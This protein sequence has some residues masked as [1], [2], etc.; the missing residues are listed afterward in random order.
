MHCHGSVPEKG[1]VVRCAG[2][3]CHDNMY[4]SCSNIVAHVSYKCIIMTVIL[5][6]G[7]QG[8]VNTCHTVIATKPM[9]ESEDNF[10]P[11]PFNTW[12]GNGTVRP[13]EGLPWKKIGAEVRNSIVVTSGSRT[14]LPG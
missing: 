2:W 10:F 13:K 9:M 6:P 5:L 11:P 3:D 14:I 12:Y 7:K 8:V 4:S 1:S